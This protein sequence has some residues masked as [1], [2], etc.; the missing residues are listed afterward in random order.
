MNWLAAKVEELD[1]RLVSVL[2]IV[3][4]TLWLYDWGCSWV[5]SW[6][7]YLASSQCWGWCCIIM[8]C[9][10]EPQHHGNLSL[11]TD[12]PGDVCFGIVN[13][14]LA[15][16]VGS[17]GLWFVQVKCLVLPMLAFPL[18]TC[19]LLAYLGQVVS[20]WNDL[21]GLATCRLQSYHPWSLIGLIELACQ[22]VG[23]RCVRWRDCWTWRCVTISK[24][25][26]IHAW[27]PLLVSNILGSWCWLVSTTGKQ[28]N[29]SAVHELKLLNWC[30]CWL[31][32]SVWWMWCDRI[33]IR[34]PLW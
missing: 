1:V 18:W 22:V 5:T 25:C 3:T 2:A 10:I 26:L 17:A 7:A 13:E 9:I 29:M 16:A 15:S 8:S 34:R 31:L 21:L 33:L 6:W 27:W 20:C 4:W 23:I 12:G 28:F 24:A 30:G 11:L 19:K 14:W 32:T